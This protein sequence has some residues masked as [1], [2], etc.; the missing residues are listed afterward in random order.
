VIFLP[1]TLLGL[2][3]S[4]N[5]YRDQGI[6]SAVDCNGPLTVMLFIVPSLVVYTAG[7]VYYA[8]LI[9]KA[10]RTLWRAVLMLLCVVIV[11]AAGRKAWAAYSEKSRPEY[12]ETCGSGW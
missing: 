3:A 6:G 10:G 5:E 9:K 7:A 11:L 2:M 8:V 12:R 4:V 1:V